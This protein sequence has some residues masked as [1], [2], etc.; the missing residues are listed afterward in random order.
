[1]TGRKWIVLW[2]ALCL[3]AAGCRTNPVT[4]RWEMMLF[5]PERELAMGDDYHPSIIFMYGG[6]HQDAEL[7]LYLGTIVRRLHECSHRPQMRTDFTVLNASVLNAF[8]TPGHVYATRGFLAQLQNEAQFAAVMGHE[9]GHV[10]AGHSAKSMSNQL[11]IGIGLGAAGVALGESVAARGVM[12]AG[13]LSVALLG[14][15]YSREQERQA[16]RLGA[17]YMA[18]AGWDP[19]E[20]I[21]MQRLLDSL[22]QR[23]ETVLDRYLST[24]P[25][26][27]SRI[28]EIESVIRQKRLTD[29]GYVQGG[30]IYAERWNRRLA[31]LM[32]VSEAYE[33]YDKGNEHLARRQYEKALEAAGEAIGMSPR[34]APFH[35][36]KG[37]ALLGLGRLAG[38]RVAYKESLRLDP[39]YVPANIGLGQLALRQERHAEAERQ[40]AVAAHGFPLSAFAHWGLG[41]ARAKLDKYAEAIAPLQTAAAAFDREPIVFYVLAVCYEETGQY[42]KAYEAYRRALSLGLEGGQRRHAQERLLVLRPLLGP[43]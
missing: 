43:P 37:D 38:A 25:P 34:Q 7:K 39:R 29:G 24:H 32:A 10:A 9:L 13:Q 20:A 23:K 4:G 2:A 40:F 19:R 41:F 35:R 14:L 22:N 5:S 16:D 15:S 31:A 8:A 11:L 30:G 6:E 42:S 36:L 21:S 28:A 3:V 27:A 18:L 26:T 17:Y 1:M 33:P 12:T